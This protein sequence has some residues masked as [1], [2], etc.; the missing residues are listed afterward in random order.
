MTYGV[1]APTRQAD[2][3]NDQTAALRHF[4]DDLDAVL[5]EARVAA[6]YAQRLVRGLGSAYY[7]AL[8]AGNWHFFIGLLASALDDLQDAGYA[9]RARAASQFWRLRAM[10]RENAD[11]LSPEMLQI[12]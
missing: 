6:S 12:G 4:I 11:L 1:L 10:V 7:A 9:P 8:A 2:L 5:G 3:D